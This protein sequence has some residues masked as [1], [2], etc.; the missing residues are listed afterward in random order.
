V[1]TDDVSMFFGLFVLNGVVISWVNHSDSRQI[2]LVLLVGGLMGF[3]GNGNQENSITRTMAGFIYSPFLIT[4]VELAA[5][6]QQASDDQ[7]IGQFD[8]WL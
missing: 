4:A 8:I 2:H 6:A 7:R 3:I 1:L 5:G